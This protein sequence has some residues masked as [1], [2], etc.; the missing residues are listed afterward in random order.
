MFWLSLTIIFAG[1][2]G[3]FAAVLSGKNEMTKLLTSLIIAVI[4]AVLLL[5]TLPQ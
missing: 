2:F 3:A 4:G 1:L 5:S